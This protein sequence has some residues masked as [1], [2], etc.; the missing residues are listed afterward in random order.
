MQDNIF[1]RKRLQFSIEKG[2]KMTKGR[3]I[4]YGQKMVRDA[5]TIEFPIKEWLKTKKNKSKVVNK[6][7]RESMIKELEANRLKHPMNDEI[8]RKLNIIETRLI[9]L[10]KTTDEEINLKKLL[11]KEN[12]L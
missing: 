10:E 1:N 8:L 2:K 3:P 7:L 9:K 4:L 11:G 5:F 6:I 12:I